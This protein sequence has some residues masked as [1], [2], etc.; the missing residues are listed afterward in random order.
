MVQC[1]AAL[2]EVKKEKVKFD[3]LIQ[4]GVEAEEVEGKGEKVANV[5]RRVVDTS[6]IS[7]CGTALG[8]L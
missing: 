5:Q 7:I 6:P 4:I 3:A 1:N 8:A 2:F